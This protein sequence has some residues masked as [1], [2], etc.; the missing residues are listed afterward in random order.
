MSTRSTNRLKVPKAEVL[1]EVFLRATARS[2]CH[3]A[4]VPRGYWIVL[5]VLVSTRVASGAVHQRSLTPV[6]AYAHSRL[7]VLP[8]WRAQL[9]VPAITDADIND[10]RWA[11]AQALS[12]HAHATLPR[13]MQ[14]HSATQHAT[15]PQTACARATTGKRRARLLLWQ[16][17]TAT[18]AT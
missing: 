9:G 7:R 16:C 13:S 3:G 6:P 5:G 4:V 14:H 2:R 11:I 18:S 10:I 17:R 12:I 1:A 8:V 15:F